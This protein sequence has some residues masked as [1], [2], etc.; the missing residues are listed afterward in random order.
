MII[1][2]NSH[3]VFFGDSITAAG[4]DRENPSSLGNGYVNLIAS[5]LLSQYP[6]WNLRITNQGVSGNRVY[7]LEERFEHDVLGLEPT[8]VT[9]LIGINDTWRRYNAD[10][11]SSKEDFQASYDRMLRTLSEKP[12]VKV[13]LCEP[14]L[15]PTLEDRR[16][17]REDLDPRITAIRE[18]AWKYRLSYLP[19]DGVFAAVASKAPFAHWLPDGVHA[20][21][22]GHA[23]IAE[24]W[25]NLAGQ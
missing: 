9:F 8:V 14:F 13:I 20:S 12:H 7:D 21:L 2:P 3:F 23:L 5:R 10:L 6:D 15:L 1:A 19:L 22:A 16:Q 25:L 18:L 4:R 11:V 17:W 24:E